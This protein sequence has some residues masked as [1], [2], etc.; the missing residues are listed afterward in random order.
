[1]PTPDPTPA[2][3]A[4]SA[5][6]GSAAGRTVVTQLLPL[7]LVVDDMPETR[8][9]MRR[10]L[11]RDRFRVIEAATGEEALRAIRSSLP[12]L[13]VLDLRL[14]GMS[15]IDV[16]HAVRASDDPAVANTILLAC[17]ASIQSE[18][19]SEALEAGCD[20]FEGKPFDVRSFA[21]RV[22]GVIERG[23]RT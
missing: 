1:V 7:I 14:P 21:A 9:L 18:V 20:D 19:R 11:E 22:R 17:T 23:R 8:R 6:A 3:T 10:V 16:A 15:G 4:A 12:A 2:T 13:V 5:E